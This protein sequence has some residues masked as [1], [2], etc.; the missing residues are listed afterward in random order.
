MRNGKKK[1]NLSET[2]QSIIYSLVDICRAT[3]IPESHRREALEKI[4]TEVEY[5][6]SLLSDFPYEPDFMDNIGLSRINAGILK[7]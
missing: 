3:N 2:K 5:R 6:L 1:I 4:K 7:G